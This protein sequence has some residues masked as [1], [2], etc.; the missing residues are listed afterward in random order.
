MDK[1]ECAIIYN[2]KENPKARIPGAEKEGMLV[3]FKWKLK[4]LC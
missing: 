2:E 4:E 3:S 1:V